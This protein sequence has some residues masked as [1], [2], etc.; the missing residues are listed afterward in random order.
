MPTEAPPKRSLA[1]AVAHTSPLLLA[2]L[3]ARQE[4]A[5]AERA[6]AMHEAT[7]NPLLLLPPPSS[8]GLARPS[9]DRG[10]LGQ[11]ANEDAEELQDFNDL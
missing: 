4:P 11:G 3:V 5:L 2:Q 6:G 9:M 8:A 10:L 7:T 1:Y